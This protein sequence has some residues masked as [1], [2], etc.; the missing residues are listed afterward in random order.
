[1]QYL[2][3]SYCSNT[4][5]RGVSILRALEAW[6]NPPLC[7]ISQHS[8]VD[9]AAEIQLLRPELRHDGSVITPIPWSSILSTNT[10]ECGIDWVNVFL[11]LAV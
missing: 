8:D 4:F 10:L 7:V 11:V 9:E 2:S 6:Y 1:M 3:V 5:L